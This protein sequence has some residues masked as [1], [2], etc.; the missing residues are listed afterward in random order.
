[1]LDPVAFLCK[2]VSILPRARH[3]PHRP[4]AIL[5]FSLKKTSF[6]PRKVKGS[7]GNPQITSAPATRRQLTPVGASWRRPTR[8]HRN[9]HY[10]LQARWRLGGLGW[11]GLGPSP[12]FPPRLPLSLPLLLSLPLPL[13][14]AACC[15]PSRPPGHSSSSS[16]RST[17]RRSRSGTAAAAK[18]NSA[19]AQ[20]QRGGLCAAHIMSVSS[21]AHA[22]RTSP[23][24]DRPRRH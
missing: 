10:F 12:P 15:G 6:S 22:R 16:S 17:S 20:L 21:A 8:P 23:T 4:P 7:G 14:W 2:N 11:A 19:A 13:G 18:N 24:D 3:V 5:L 9:L 1:M